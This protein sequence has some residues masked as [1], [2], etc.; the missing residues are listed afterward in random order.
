MREFV[1]I[2][3]SSQIGVADGDGVEK[4]LRIFD[5]AEQCQVKFV[6]RELLLFN[7]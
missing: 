6:L 1:C 5:L 4:F 2:A 3:Y 7:Q